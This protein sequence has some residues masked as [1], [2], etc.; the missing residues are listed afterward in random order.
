MRATSRLLQRQGYEGTRV[1]QI[2]GDAG[3]TLGSVYHFFPGGKQE[4][5][6]H[7]IRHGEQD[8]ADILRKG[9]DSKADPAEAI[10]ACTRVL[11][12][13]LRRSG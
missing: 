2:A 1:K 13:E 10:V 7:A 5:A 11:A 4:L 12:K 8:F 9:L 3:A 6:A